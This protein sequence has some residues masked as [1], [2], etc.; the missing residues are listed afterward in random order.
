MIALTLIAAIG[1]VAV[2]VGVA[3]PARRRHQRERHDVENMFSTGPDDR[4]WWE[5]Q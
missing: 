5:A 2:A 1:V 4:M 3:L